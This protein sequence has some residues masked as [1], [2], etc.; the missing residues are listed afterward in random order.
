MRPL[1]SN[2]EVEVLRAWITADS[3]HTVAR[4]LFITPA[5]VSTHLT[6]IRDKYHDAGRDANCKA[7]LLA[8]ALQDGHIAL[9]EI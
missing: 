6:R 9:D 8:R 1:L 5:T 7:T 3:K 2:R 4:Q